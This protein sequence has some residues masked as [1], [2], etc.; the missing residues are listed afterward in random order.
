[1]AVPPAL[2]PPRIGDP[3][4]KELSYANRASAEKQANYWNL[5]LADDPAFGPASGLVVGVAPT[6][7]EEGL[8]QLVWV[9]PERVDALPSDS[10]AISQSVIPD[11]NHRQRSVRKLLEGETAGSNAQPSNRAG[12]RNRRKNQR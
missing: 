6:K 10:A 8:Y 2:N 11:G 3:I 12:R 7:N 1:M 4:S 9:I 5:A